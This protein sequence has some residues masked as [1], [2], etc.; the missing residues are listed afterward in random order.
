MPAFAPGAAVASARDANA[1][2]LWLRRV[3][4]GA[5]AL[6]LVSLL[7]VLIWGSGG[8]VEHARMKQELEQMVQLNQAKAQRNSELHREVERFR[9]GDPEQ[10]DS[11]ARTSLGMISA[12]E[13]LVVFVEEEEEG[14]GAEP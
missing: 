12:D 14:A 11:Y 5:S 2:S 9:A 6:V 4:I 10:I 7:W 3:F 13:S 1:T 8:Y